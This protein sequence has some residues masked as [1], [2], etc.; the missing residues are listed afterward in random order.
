MTL[1]MQLAVATAMTLASMLLH[2]LGLSALLLII[3]QRRRLEGWRHDAWAVLMA[4]IGL[5][6]LHGAEIWGYALF[7]VACGALG[8]FETALYFSTATY[9]TIGYGDVVLARPWRVIGAIEGAGGII[10]LGWS[11][12]FFV[13]MV[14]RINSIENRVG[15]ET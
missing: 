15:R 7:Y 4:A 14:C 1:P 6:I 5:F 13:A 12:A 2:L 11:T 3:R 10:L 9:T 8:D